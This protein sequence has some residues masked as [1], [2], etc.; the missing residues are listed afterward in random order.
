MTVSPILLNY[1][2]FDATTKHIL[3]F[4][5]SGSQVFGHRVVVKRND[6]L[7]QVYDSGIVES[8]ALQAVINANTL[9]NGHTYIFQLSVLC[10]NTEDGNKIESPFSTP[11]ILK[12]FATPNFNFVDITEGTTIRNSYFDAELSYSCEDET[13]ALNQYKIVLYASDTTTPLFDSGT[14]YI[15]SGLTVRISG[16]TD[17]ETYYLRAT[18]ETLS[19]MEIDTGLIQIRCNYIK[20]DL[21]LSF[22]AN[23]VP[24]DGLV[25]LSSNFVMIEGGTDSESLIY[26]DGEKVNL[27]NGDTVYFNSG[28]HA[29]NFTCDIVAENMIDFSTIIK[30]DM[31]YVQT[32]VQ[33]CK[34]IFEDDEFETYY[35]ELIATFYVGYEPLNYI[36]FSNRIEAPEEGEQVHFWIKHVNGT[37]DVKIAKLDKVEEIDETIKEGEVV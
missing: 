6:T 22:Y 16:L 31:G 2:P 36:Q 27:L 20:P 5:Y 13:E 3:Q 35:A 19:G 21:F 28:Y 17:L 30:F 4:S 24:E 26:V 8:M 33:W 11:I 18:G 25:Q 9:T 23:N 12:C 37:F 7:E 1:L 14:R 15:I 10:L 32:S 34:G 29:T